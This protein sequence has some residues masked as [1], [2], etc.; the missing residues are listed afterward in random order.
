VLDRAAALCNNDAAGA[1]PIAAI[2]FFGDAVHLR[3]ESLIY[4]CVFGY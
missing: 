4:A 3:K 2:E 1:A